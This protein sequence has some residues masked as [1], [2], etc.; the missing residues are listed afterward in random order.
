MVFVVNRYPLQRGRG[1]GGIFANILKKIIPFGKT[2]LKGGVKMGKEFM[3]SET[4]KSILKDSIDSATTAAASALLDKNP[5]EAKE[6]VVE[7][8]KRSRSKSSA[9]AKR[10]AKDKL[11]KVL[12]GQGEGKKNRKRKLEK[13]LLNK[14]KRKRAKKQKITSLLD[15]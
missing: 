13:V 5:E 2:F 6:K 11:E 4:G 14:S 12:T 3:S 15:I 10:L 9:Y 7:S 8:L 1:L